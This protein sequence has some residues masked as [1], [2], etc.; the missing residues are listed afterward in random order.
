MHRT[1]VCILLGVL[2]IVGLMVST[3]TAPNATAAPRSPASVPGCADQD[4]GCGY[5]HGFAEG[6]TASQLGLCARRYYAYAD[7][8]VPSD[9]GFRDAFEHYC[10][11]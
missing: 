2:L 1:F 3:L 6:R 10:P 9:Q 7:N 4:Y 8:L 11:A 5:L